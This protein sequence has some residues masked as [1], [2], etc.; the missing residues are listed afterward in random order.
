MAEIYYISSSNSMIAVKIGA[1]GAQFTSGVGTALFPA[2]I[3]PG[4]G[5]DVSADGKYFAIN[6][7]IEETAT[8]I[9]LLTNWTSLLNQ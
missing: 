7:S 8:S 3:E 4:M 2:T 5:F 1:Q 6:S 9:S